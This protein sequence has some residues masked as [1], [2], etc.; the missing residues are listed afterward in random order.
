MNAQEADFGAWHISFLPHEGARIITLKFNGWDLL[1][2]PPPIFSPPQHFYGEYETRPVFGYDDCFPTVDQCD[3]PGGKFRC[4]DH[5]ELCWQEWDVRHERHGLVFTT[6]C[7]QPAVDFKRQLSFSGNSLKWKFEV[8]SRTALRYAF[9]HVMHALMVRGNIVKVE[10]PGCKNIIDEIKSADT[11]F[12][13]SEEAATHLMTIKAGTF[14][15]LLLR[16]ID[17]G[18]LNLTFRN[19]IIL[20]ISF[21]HRLFPTLGI[22]WN[23]GGYPE[24]AQARA[25]CAF[26]PIPGTCSDLSK[27]F[28]DG[29][30]LSAGPG[31]KTSWEIIWTIK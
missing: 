25:E 7:Y 20:Q 23:N 16:E 10:L 29:V 9:L 3:Y 22:W 11:G 27:S 30:Y 28:A 1:T 31:E 13:S 12:K 26:E 4:R 15:M 19:G 6:S 8:C 17:T 5:G 21:E 2:P 18:I 24:E 14:I